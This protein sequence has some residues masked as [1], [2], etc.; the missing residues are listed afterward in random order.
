MNR[1]DWQKEAAQGAPQ[2]AVFSDAVLTE[3][4]QTEEVDLELVGAVHARLITEIDPKKL[5]QLKPE[6]SR[7][8]VM[9]AARRT[10][11][12]VAPQV[13]GDSRD[14][15]LDAVADEVLGLGP[16]EKLVRD[17][18]I[19]EI[20]VN[21]PDHVYFEQDGIIYKSRINFRDD[22]HIMRIIQRIVAPLGRRVDEASPYVDARLPDGSRVNIVIPP[23]TFHGPVITIRKFLGDKYTF[24]DLVN[25]GTMSQN[26]ADFLLKCIEAKLNT[27]ISGGTGTG[28]TTLLNALSSAIGSKER[29][30]TIEDPAEL[31]LQQEHVISMEVRPANIEGRNE[32]TQRDLVRNALRMRPDRIIVGEVRGAEAFDMMQAMNTGHEGSLTTVHANSPR[33]ALARIENMVLMAGFELPITAIREQIASALHLIIQITRMSDGTRKITS[34]TE[35]TGQEGNTISMQ[36]LF[37]FE[38]QGVDAEGRIIGSLKP[39]GLRPHFLENFTAAGIDLPVQMFLRNA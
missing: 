13:M 34:V 29:I 30:V 12:D 11:T 5:A 2:P 6:Q 9:L 31:K 22:E 1:W 38:R 26:V 33:D 32:V 21:A 15:I 4:R 24:A 16:I 10:L 28:K 14:L 39:T 27:L 37:T 25:V 3:E 7:E 23:I 19:S 35:I 18:V 36:D 20:M 8:A 17:P